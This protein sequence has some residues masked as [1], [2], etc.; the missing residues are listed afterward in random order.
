MGVHY[1]MGVREGRLRGAT[2]MASESPSTERVERFHAIY[3][4]NHLPILGYALRRTSSEED[5]ADVVAETFLVLWRRLDDV[6]PGEETKPWLYGIARH[7]ISNGQ[8]SERR[9][10]R[11]L[12]RM[13]A[14]R[15][16]EGADVG[17]GSVVSNVMLQLSPRDRELLRL[18]AWEDLTPAEIGIAFGCSTNAAKV[19]LHRAR[20]RF[21][22]Q[23]GL[24]DGSV[25]PSAEAGHEDSERITPA[26][27][28]LR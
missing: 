5:A 25:K 20:K 17:V 23:L 12:A 21:A 7:V 26:G 1:R 9:R 28:D 22:L 16:A 27:K 24:L 3:L 18:A 6:P 8:R 15:R 14:S 19:R 10:R 2:A 11:L 4:D 13:R